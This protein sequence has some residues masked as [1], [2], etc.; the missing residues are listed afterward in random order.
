MVNEILKASGI[1]Y[2]RTRFLKPPSGNYAVFTDDVDTDG[3]DGIAAIYHHNITVELYTRTPDVQAEMAIENAI[4]SHDLQFEKQA[5][6]WIPAEQ[7]YQVIY[8]F[9]Y[10]VKRRI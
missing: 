10:K 3:P 5:A 9:E 1:P 7:L 8:E 6:Y 2:R 4:V